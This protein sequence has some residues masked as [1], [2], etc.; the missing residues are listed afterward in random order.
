M[1]IIASL[2]FDVVPVCSF[3]LGINALVKLQNW[4]QNACRHARWLTVPTASFQSVP[5]FWRQGAPLSLVRKSTC[6]IHFFA[7]TSSPFSLLSPYFMF[8]VQCW[9]CLL[10]S[11]RMCR[12][13]CDTESGR[14]RLQKIYSYSGHMVDHI[15]QIQYL[16]LKKCYYW[17]IAPCST[18]K[19]ILFILSTVMSRTVLW[20]PVVLVDR[21]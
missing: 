14:R 2:C 3:T 6:Y 8:R 7:V 13:N 18:Q 12:E 11:Y 5:L 9:E 21:Y 1:T 19:I 15:F 20:D 16:D 17:N 4:W 10:W